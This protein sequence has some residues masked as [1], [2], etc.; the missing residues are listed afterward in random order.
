MT[1]LRQRQGVSPELAVAV[2]AAEAAAVI[3]LLISHQLLQGVDRLHARHARLPG[4]QL[5]LL[6]MKTSTLPALVPCSS[7]LIKKGFPLQ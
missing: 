2:R 1:V 6:F 5:E 4:R 3:D 7:C